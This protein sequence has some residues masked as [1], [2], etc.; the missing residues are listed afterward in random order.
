MEKH[1]NLLSKIER[2]IVLFTL[3][4]LLLINYT[5]SQIEFKVNEIT[6]SHIVETIKWSYY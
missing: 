4:F 3:L 1:F 6:V 2:I 5:Y